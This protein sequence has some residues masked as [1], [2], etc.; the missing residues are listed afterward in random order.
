M[1]PFI[2]QEEARLKV[3]NDVVGNA[4]RRTKYQTCQRK[5][6]SSALIALR[7]ARHSRAQRLFTFKFTFVFKPWHKPTAMTYVG[8]WPLT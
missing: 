1:V 5:T 4:L 2:R 8:T 7:C 3:I 6:A